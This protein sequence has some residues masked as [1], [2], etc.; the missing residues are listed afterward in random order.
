MSV[1]PFAIRIL[2]GLQEHLKIMSIEVE[3]K[4][5]VTLLTRQQLEAMG[6]KRKTICTFT[7]VY[8]DVKCNT[9]MLSDCWLRKRDGAWELKHP[10]VDCAGGQSIGVG[11]VSDRY[12]ELQSEDD[13]LTFLRTVIAT[14]IDICNSGA[15][16]L[17]QLVQEGT[18]TRIAEFETTRETYVC[19]NDRHREMSG[20]VVHVDLDET[21]FG[22]VVGEV[23]L[24]VGR[25]E[26]IPA[27]EAKTLAIAKQIGRQVWAVFS[28]RH[29]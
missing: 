8:L 18:L 27:A 19:K 9:L 4:F 23:E 7:D 28:I 5:T 11:Q 25:G 21:N 15:K 1:N 13:I 3:H 20:S 26:D 12:N 6:A 10:L 14:E 22:Y 17:D 24:M 2:A 16:S 29:S